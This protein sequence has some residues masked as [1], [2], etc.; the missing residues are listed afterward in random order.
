MVATGTTPGAITPIHSQ[1]ARLRNHYPNLTRL[2][3]LVPKIL[4]Y[5]AL[6]KPALEGVF[7]LPYRLEGMSQSSIKSIRH[8]PS[9]LLSPTAAHI[10]L[11]ACLLSFFH[12]C[13][14]CTACSLPLPFQRGSVLCSEPLFLAC[15]IELCPC[16]LPYAPNPKQV[17]GKS[18]CSQLSSP[19][20]R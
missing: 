4:P 13:T 6:V 7:P 18:P 1:F 11:L 10:C 19:M 17:Q 12:L 20:I 14:P 5:V 15:R 3:L 16:L 2:V 9:L 8:G